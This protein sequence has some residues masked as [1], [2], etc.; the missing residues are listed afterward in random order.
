MLN[1][2]IQLAGNWKERLYLFQ[3]QFET[4]WDQLFVFKTGQ[5]WKQK[6]AVVCNNFFNFL[7][8]R[9]VEMNL[10]YK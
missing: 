6:I 2:A 8:Y 7:L 3:Q 10:F 4:M 9:L 1:F 5:Y